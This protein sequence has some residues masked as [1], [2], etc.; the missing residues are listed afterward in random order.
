MVTFEIIKSEEIKFGN[1]NFLEIAR[2]KAISEEGENV[3]ISISRGFITPT[4]EKRYRKSFTVPIDESV[5]NFITE[6]LKEI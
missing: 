6:K 4:G 5:I 2:K 1:S 3:F